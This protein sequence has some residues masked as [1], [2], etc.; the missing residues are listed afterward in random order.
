[1]DG[2]VQV[3]IT[4]RKYTWHEFVHDVCYVIY[5]TIVISNALCK[6]FFNLSIPQLYHHIVDPVKRAIDFV[7]DFVKNVLLA[8][9]VIM[10][11]ILALAYSVLMIAGVL[12]YL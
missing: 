9:L 12:G 5:A 1:M 6:R 7:G 2:T 4:V 8:I 10:I 3:R 11:G